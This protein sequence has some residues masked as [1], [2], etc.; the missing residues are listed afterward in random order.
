MVQHQFFQH[1]KCSRPWVLFV[2]SGRERLKITGFAFLLKPLLL[3]RR[4]NRVPGQGTVCGHST[5]TTTSASTIAPAVNAGQTTTRLWAVLTLEQL[6][7]YPQCTSSPP[8][9]KYPRAPGG[10]VQVWRRQ[11]ELSGIHAFKLGFVCKVP[12]VPVSLD[13]SDGC[14]FLSP[15]GAVQSCRSTSLRPQPRLWSRRS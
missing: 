4:K 8:P 13:S 11:T 3:D 2:A 1:V 7:A 14:I 5:T 10:V 6:S 15:Q 12:R 9:S